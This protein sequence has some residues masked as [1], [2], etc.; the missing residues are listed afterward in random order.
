M[1]VKRGDR[2]TRE[3]IF[4]DEEIANERV[5]QI[6]S[7]T[8]SFYAILYLFYIEETKED[9]LEEVEDILGYI[10]R[11]RVEMLVE[12]FSGLVGYH[13]D[14]IGILYRRLLSTDRRLLLKE[15]AEDIVEEEVAK[16]RRY[17]LKTLSLQEGYIEIEK[18][19]LRALNNKVNE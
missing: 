17:L 13:E 9:S 3:A 2:V 14:S 19:E 11:G 6:N 7:K 5:R 12:L 8:S 4:L 1:K 10:N 15:L 16:I 18:D